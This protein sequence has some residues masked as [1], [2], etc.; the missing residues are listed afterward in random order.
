MTVVVCGAC[1]V[2]L[3]SESGRLGFQDDELHNVLSAPF[4]SGGAIATGSRVCPSFDGYYDAA[5]ETY[6]GDGS[7]RSC[8]EPSITGPARLDGECIE[9][10]GPGEVIWSL[11]RT[12]SECAPDTTLSSDRVVFRSVSLDGVITEEGHVFERLVPELGEPLAGMEPPAD[13]IVPGDQPLLVAADV[14]V[15]LRPML[16]EVATGEEVAW[17]R[18]TLEVPTGHMVVDDATDAWLSVPEGQSAEAW[19]SVRD[20]T[21]PPLTVEG[22]AVGSLQQLEIVPYCVLGSGLGDWW[23]RAMARDPSGRPVRGVP[24]TWSIE[25]DGSLELLYSESVSPDYIAVGGPS[26]EDDE[27]R[28]FRTTVEATLGDQVARVELA[29]TPSSC[30]VPEDQGLSD[31]GCA[32]TSGGASDSLG[33][34][35]LGLL[36]AVPRSRRHRARRQRWTPAP[37]RRAP[38]RHHPRA[39]RC[40]GSW[41]HPRRRA[42]PPRGPRAAAPPGGRRPP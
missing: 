21:S 41:C 2:D 4:E 26:D 29:W 31:R 38:A 17:A 30:E 37:A 35:S 8:F 42:A 23:L 3:Y 34:P 33:W 36:F 19:I 5:L 24:V 40:R 9:I 28:V 6:R 12:P 11:D 15:E 39:V 1:D 22:V 27:T 14:T 10:D 13:W 18:G 25:G 32:C 7:I 16:R 20:A